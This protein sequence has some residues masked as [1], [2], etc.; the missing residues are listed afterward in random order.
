MTLTLSEAN[1][2]PDVGPRTG[3]S[4]PAVPDITRAKGQRPG[5]RLTEE[6]LA[7]AHGNGRRELLRITLPIDVDVFAAILKQAGARYPDA[8]VDG[9]AIACWVTVPC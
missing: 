9:D 7:A 8:R 4:D 1:H 3:H 5:E 6:E 2:D